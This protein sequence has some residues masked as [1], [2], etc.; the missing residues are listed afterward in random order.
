MRRPFGVNAIVVLLLISAVLEVAGGGA[1]FS[2]LLTGNMS[3]REYF[4]Q[5]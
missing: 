1:A 2:L 4:P 3:I 5:A